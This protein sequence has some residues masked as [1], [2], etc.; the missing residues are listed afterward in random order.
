[1]AKQIKT[2]VAVYAPLNICLLFIMYLQGRKV[3]LDSTNEQ[4]M[5][6]ALCHHTPRSFSVR[7]RENDVEEIYFLPLFRKATFRRRNASETRKFTIIIIS[8]KNIKT[9]T[10]VEKPVKVDWNKHFCVVK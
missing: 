1:M 2:S 9:N 3:I 4:S 5:R 7:D 8:K 6:T 10:S